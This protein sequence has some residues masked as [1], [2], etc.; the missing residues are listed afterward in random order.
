MAILILAALISCATGIS[1][2]PGNVTNPTGTIDHTTPYFIELLGFGNTFGED[3]WG[4]ELRDGRASPAYT[5][6]AEPEIG[7]IWGSTDGPSNFT[8]CNETK[9]YSGVVVDLQVLNVS[10]NSGPSSSRLITQ[11]GHLPLALGWSLQ[12][13]NDSSDCTSFKEIETVPFGLNIGNRDF[14]NGSLVLGG[15]YDANSIASTS[16]HLIPESVGNSSFLE[17]GMLEISVLVNS[18]SYNAVLDYTGSWYQF[19]DGLEGAC[20]NDDFI[21]SFPGADGGET[22]DI[23]LNLTKSHNLDLCDDEIGG[24][25][26]D[27]GLPFFQEIY[28]YVDKMGQIYITAASHLKAATVNM[29]P[30]DANATLQLPAGVTAYTVPTASPTKK[31]IASS[32][33]APTGFVIFPYRIGW[34]M[35]STGLLLIAWVTF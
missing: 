20:R 35:A 15:W 7:G 29:Q 19:H 32:S 10:T 12:E 31:S 28:T 8:A 25:A 24:T 17:T 4:V 6:F 26:M 13:A 9:T 21:I 11:E 18:Q 30:F 22:F 34:H 2:V 1:S 5:F 14:Y 3:N 33:F 23:S 16:W 27:L